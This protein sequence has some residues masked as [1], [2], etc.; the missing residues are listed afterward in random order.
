V[1]GIAVE[2]ARVV[3]RG[4]SLAGLVIL[5]LLLVSAAC[6]PSAPKSPSKEVGELTFYGDFETGDPSQWTW[7]AQ[8]ANTGV[9][10]DGAID[11][12]T[13]TVQSEIVAQG[14]Y[15]ARFDLPAA[16]VPSACETVRKRTLELSEQ[17]YALEFR[18][19][20]DWQEPSPT[21]WGMA[22]AQ[23]NY[24]KIWGAPIGIY[25]HADQVRLILNSGLC[26]PVGT[27]SPP[28]PGCANNSGPTGNLAPMYVI[29][30]ALELGVWHQVLVH[31][32]WATDNSGL[33]Q[34]FQ[35]QR[36]EATWHQEVNF[37]GKPTVQWTATLPANPANVTI[38]KIGAY[39]GQSAAPLSVWHD[40]FCVE[41]TRVAAE[42]CL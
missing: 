41:A 17:W 3:K 33:L 11:R 22:I 34:V 27:P 1:Y 19:P 25:A 15:A 37:S 14:K 12:G 4:R 30:R 24:Q 2:T 5:S 8:C 35:R 29:P 32:R 38:D 26:R 28:G 21:G 23:L 36:G 9:P 7:G 42:S 20:L 18:F 39:R 31:V 16:T 13:I 6:A 10:S 40:A